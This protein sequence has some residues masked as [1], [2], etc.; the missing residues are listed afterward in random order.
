VE[1]PERTME[2]PIASILSSCIRDRESADGVQAAPESRDKVESG[3]TCMLRL[4]A[5]CPHTLDSASGL[6]SSHD[7]L[8]HRITARS[9]WFSLAPDSASLRDPPGSL[10]SLDLQSHHSSPDTITVTRMFRRSQPTGRLS[11]LEATWFPP[12]TRDAHPSASLSLSNT[13]HDSVAL[14]CV[15]TPWIAFS[16]AV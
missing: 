6:P 16:A 15:Q 5:C 10:W 3:S 13:L 2:P 4:I 11:S 12:F 1:P 7:G 9:V 14:A 8:H